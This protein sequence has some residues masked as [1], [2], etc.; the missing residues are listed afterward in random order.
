MRVGTIKLCQL[1]SMSHCFVSQAQ[2]AES[3]CKFAVGGYYTTGGL[4]CVQYSAKR[5][6]VHDNKCP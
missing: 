5:S 3:S 4:E 2:F 6:V 1:G